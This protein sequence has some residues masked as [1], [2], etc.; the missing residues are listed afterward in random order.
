MR[1][2]QHIIA[3]CVELEEIL[4]LINSLD[5]QSVTAN[6]AEV[7]EG[8]KLVPENPTKEMQQAGS[9]VKIFTGYDGMDERVYTNTTYTEIRDI[10][11]RMLE[12][13]PLPPPNDGAK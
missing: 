13:A 1:G 10:Y 2:I 5:V 9:S 7:P 12:A 3:R 4:P 8:W 6:K 11:E